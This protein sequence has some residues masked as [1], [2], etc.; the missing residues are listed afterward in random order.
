MLV[1]CIVHCW[2]AELLGR[3]AL[4]VDLAGFVGWLALL[5]WLA[6][7]IGWLALH[8]GMADLVDMVSLDLISYHI[9]NKQYH[10]HVE[11]TINAGR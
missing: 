6:L 7:L 8:V 9:S 2:L 3:L 10:L 1:P 11:I 5:T 4:L